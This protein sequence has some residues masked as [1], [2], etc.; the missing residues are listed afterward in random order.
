VL[1][2]K[3][4]YWTHNELAA[5]SGYS[6]REKKQAKKNKLVKGTNKMQG[7]DKLIFYLAYMMKVD[8]S[9]SYTVVYEDRM[10]GGLECPIDVFLESHDIPFHRI[11]MFKKN[12]EVVWDR[13]N[14]FSSI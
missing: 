2:V 8:P 14:K 4:V 3:Q 5:L 1:E 11:F 7:A 9:V 6:F 10:L 12:G 13:R